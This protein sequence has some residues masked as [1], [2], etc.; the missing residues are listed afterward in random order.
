MIIASAIFGMIYARNA[1]N[2][3]VYAYN[4]WVLLSYSFTAYG[5]RFPLYAQMRMILIMILRER[6]IIIRIKGK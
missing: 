2:F 5:Y 6:M 3:K 4:M 1:Y